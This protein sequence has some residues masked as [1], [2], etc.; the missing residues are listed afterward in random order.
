MTDQPVKSTFR[1][2]L[3]YDASCGFCSRW[4]P[5]WSETLAA[6]G[7]D[8]APLQSDFARREFTLPD[9]E[10]SNDLRLSLADGSKLSGANVYRHVLKHIWWAWPIYWLAIVPGLSSVFDGCY[11][12]FARNRFR[13]SRACRMPGKNV[14][15]SA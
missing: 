15:R 7:F 5:F 13:V 4:I 11:Q 2:T 10:L 6:R 1:G 3:F 12:A 9:D 14:S 8:I